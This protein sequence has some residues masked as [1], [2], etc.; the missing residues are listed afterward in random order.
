[1]DRQFDNF[2][3]GLHFMHLNVRSLLAKNKFD[4][5]KAQITNSNISILTISESW[6]NTKI[7]TS[8]INIPGY[9]SSR[10]DRPKTRSTRG[11]GLITY[12][13]DHLS[14]DDSKFEHLNLMNKDIE[15]QC[16]DLFIPN[17]RQIIMLNLYRPPQGSVVNFIKLLNDTIAKL[18]IKSNTEIYLM[19]D[20]NIDML[21][22]K[23]KNVKDLFQSA[24][25]SG[26]LPLI[27]EYT[28]KSDKS[29]CIDQI[30]TNCDCI[31][32]SGVV[33]INISDHFAVFCTRKKSSEKGIKKEF[34][35][36]S[37]R[38][39]IKEDFQYN[40]INLDWTPFYV[41][42][43]P[44]EC[45]DIME[46]NIKSEIDKMCPVKTFKVAA[47]RDPWI[48]NELLEE[49]RD[50]DLALKRARKSGATEDWAF[51]RNERNRVGRMVE[52]ARR[53]FF[54][55]EQVNSRGD[56]KRFWRN[57]A[58]AMPGKKSNNSKI[59]LIDTTS[60]SKIDNAA[61]SNYINN[62]FSNIGINLAKEFNNT[63]APSY[64]P[65]NDTEISEIHTD[66]EEVRTLCKEINTSKSSAL[67]LLSSRILKDAFL[68][69]GLQL[70]YLFNLSL[71]LR[72]FPEK[73]KMATV[74]PLYK[75]GSRSEV[76]N[77][78]PIS[79]L[80]LP[81]KIL[82][83]IV[84][85]RISTFLESNK[86]LCTEQCG[87][88]KECSTTLSIVNLTDSLFSAI[89]KQET[90]MAVFIDLKKA[91]D[92][93]NHSILLKKLHHLGIR[94]DLLLWISNY[95]HDRFQRTF[96][97]NVLSDVL[98][99]KCGVP[100]GSILGPLF[101]ITYINDIK[102]H[103]GNDNIGL[104]ADDTVL[105]SHNTDKNV[106]RTDLQY[107][108]N[109][110]VDWSVMNELTINV[111]KTKSMVFGTRSIVKKAKSLSLS[112][113]DTQIQQV[114]SFKYLGFTLD[115]VL[116]FT[117]HIS[118]LLNV[119]SH[120]AY[121]LSK[122][123]RFVTEYSAIRIY[124]AMVLPY[125]DYADIVYD[126]ARQV[127]LDKLQRAQ[128]KCLKT[129]M[130]VNC[131]T[132]TDYVHSYTKVP[133][134]IDRRK[135]HLRNFMFQRKKNKSLLDLTEVCTRSR[136]APLFKTDFPKC[137]AYKRSVLYNG[138]AEWNALDVETRNVDLL[139]P[140]KFRQRR[141]LQDTIR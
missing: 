89:N 9:I 3:K 95:L 130:L 27:N 102:M 11:G 40:I 50:K 18:K 59:S 38:N 63:W 14:F 2:G 56:P 17:M 67:D 90:C 7:P 111:R 77:Y 112:I 120:K 107:N 99:V 10:L 47:S 97:N 114:P 12:I 19:G 119:I 103:I 15:L 93:V 129:C 100:Q 64:P 131:R 126:K 115:S 29:T 75:G 69:L 62:F 83:K 44:I 109:K 128:N 82:E 137:E 73:W 55:E 53:E 78:R 110:F 42:T 39:Y 80:P 68:V 116:S 58:S 5:L 65:N 105:F 43:D 136:D 8:M 48:T 36:R 54:E 141:W 101:F 134:L 35:G 124:K 85:N 13:A 31:C 117:N 16:L 60:Q 132:D 57:I 92:T 70:V 106:A 24:K 88:R 91:F 76:G 61:T 46:H 6:L 4:M 71:S 87:F 135:V 37:Y 138:A 66:F 51:A 140:F 26:A 34:S 81:G 52:T 84:H 49:I 123:R 30:F 32:D 108:L 1:M 94:G 25:M 79:L 121:I 125:F 96:A 28:R 133:K 33:D 41:C 72:D 45:W 139:L 98:P 20:F 21:D 113:G 74:I 127:D 22:K 86:L 122:I 104:Y 118:T 23:S